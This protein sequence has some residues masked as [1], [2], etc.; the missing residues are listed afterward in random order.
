[1][2]E[3]LVDDWL[4][5]VNELGYQLP[6]CDVL[7]TEGYS[8]IHVSTHGRGEHGKDIVARR[9][10]GVLTTFQLKGGDINLTKWRAM[11]G[12]VEELVHLPAR[13]PGVLEDEPH[14]PH[15]VTNGEIRGDALESIARYSDTWAAKGYPRMEVWTRRVV[16]RKFLDAHGSYLPANLQDFRWFVELYVGDFESPLPKAKFARLLET[17]AANSTDLSATEM[18]R[19]LPAISIVGSY[20]AEQYGRSQNHLAAAEAWTIIAAAILRTAEASG[21]DLEIYGGALRVARAAFERELDAFA[22]EV[23]D[24]TDLV[25]RKGGLVDGNVYGA[26]VS[27]VLGWLSA[28]ALGSQL[29]RARSVQSG[30]VF[31]VIKREWPA[32]RYAGE[33]DWP[34]LLCLALQLDAEC[35]PN[36][37]ESVLLQYVNALLQSNRGEKPGGIP[38]PYW[39]HE[40]VLKLANQML[41]PYEQEQ[42]GGRSFTMAQALDALVRRLRRQSVK[43]AWPDASHLDFCDFSPD[44]LADYFLWRC[45]TGALKTGKPNLSASWSAWREAA[46]SLDRTQVPATLLRHPEWVLPY[47]LTYPHRAN[48]VMSKLAE[49][50]VRRRISLS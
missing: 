24:S 20:I 35:L 1:M 21:A 23:L 17:L 22:E 38:S 43:I 28:W 50:S 34:F 33:V 31:N 25:A 47:L 40:K 48:R 6:F 10:D 39:S 42:F 32:H 4:T 36:D 27:I 8:I 44:Q 11:R 49:W 16:L 29:Y 7:L 37:A 14:I 45:E 18:R 41:A 9:A 15:L 5:N 12:E 26:R 2:H 3:R 46:A 30:R 19:A 13:V